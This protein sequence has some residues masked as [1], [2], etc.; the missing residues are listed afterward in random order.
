MGLLKARLV[1]SRLDIE[2]AFEARERK[3]QQ[4]EEEFVKKQAQ[5]EKEDEIKTS[6]RR[7]E[8]EAKAASKR[9]AVLLEDEWEAEVTLDFAK[10]AEHLSKRMRK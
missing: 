9:K 6:E 8:F 3:L 4:A 10:R 2:D 7:R 1:K 5:F